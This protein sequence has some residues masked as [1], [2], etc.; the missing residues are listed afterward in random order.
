[1]D[2]TQPKKLYPEFR[3]MEMREDGLLMDVK[4]RWGQT[5]S[6]LGYPFDSREKAL[7]ALSNHVAN[8]EDV[9]MDTYVLVESYKVGF[10]WGD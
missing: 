1:M 9:F 7:E 3:W 2:M 5:H 6:R 10:D 4:D 8:D